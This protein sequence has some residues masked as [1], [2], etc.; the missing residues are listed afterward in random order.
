MKNLSLTLLFSLLLSACA[1]QETK[2]EQANNK[3]STSDA[4]GELSNIPNWVLSPQI[5]NGIADSACV[6]W[7]GNVTIDKDEASHI[8]RTRLAKQIEVRS[9]GMSKAF[10]NKTTTSA[11][12]N[13]GTN[14]E[15]TTRQIFEQTLKGTKS[16]KVGLFTIDKQ[17]Q[18][19]VM[20]EL[21]PAK[22]KQLYKNIISANGAQL[23]AKDEDI[24]FT[25]FKAQ[26]AQK[27]L[28]EV[29]KK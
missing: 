22:T 6:A 2:Q 27:E 19:C 13:T 20:V 26:Q 28:E 9:A 10:A 23:N 3:L 7:S 29:L 15:N 14:F 16:T 8:A 11:G 1:S 17:K 25:Q 24:L 21:D 18:F 4:N 5:E 12:L